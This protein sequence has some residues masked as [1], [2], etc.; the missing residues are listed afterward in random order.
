MNSVQKKLN[1]KFFMYGICYFAAFTTKTS[2]R[3]ICRYY[4]KEQNAHGERNVLPKMFVG[5]C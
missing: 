4:E 1:L 2:E 3:P 5:G